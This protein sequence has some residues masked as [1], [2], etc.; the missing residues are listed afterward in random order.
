MKFTFEYFDQKLER[1][2]LALPPQSKAKFLAIL[3]RLCECGPDVQRLPHIR[4]MT[5]GLWEIR[6]IA[7]DGSCRVF[8]CWIGTET[9]VLLHCF[10]KKSQET[11]KHELD[12]ALRR[13]K[14]VKNG[15]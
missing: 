8:Y 4:Y 1:A 13:M 5:D 3:K 9:F 15:K 6:A 7:A 2:I 10:L 11:P 14:E 12:K